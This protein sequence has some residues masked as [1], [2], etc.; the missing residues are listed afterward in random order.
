LD[1]ET[2][3][4][5]I[6]SSRKLHNK[7]PIAYWPLGSLEWYGEHLPLGSDGLQAKHFFEILALTVGGIG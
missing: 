4:K 1:Y 5:T 6:C 7:A 2:F 3:Q